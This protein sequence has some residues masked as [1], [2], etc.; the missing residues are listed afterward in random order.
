MQLEG[1][2][3]CVLT[4]RKEDTD[5]LGNAASPPPHPPGG[6]E[7]QG[8]EAL[9]WCW[10]GIYRHSP[11][12][13]A[14]GRQPARSWCFP[15]KVWAVWFPTPAFNAVPCGDTSPGNRGTSPT[16]PKHTF[17]LETWGELSGLRA[18][19]LAQP[20]CPQHRLRTHPRVLKGT[21]GER[22]SPSLARTVCSW[23][24]VRLFLGKAPKHVPSCASFL[25]QP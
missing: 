3:Q 1:G 8:P 22:V 15:N 13:T 18:L 23:C 14:R 24:S 19:S 17:K 12:D 6:Q 2:P 11:V 10:L 4:V 25:K 21:P 20:C 7:P 5:T 16:G 9:A